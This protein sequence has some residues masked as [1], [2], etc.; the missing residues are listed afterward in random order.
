MNRVMDVG[1]ATIMADIA[2]IWDGLERA[3]TSD[4]R[5]LRDAIASTDLNTGDRNFFMLRGAK[6]SDKG[7]NEK[8]VGIVT[9]IQNGLA[10]PVW[11][12]NLRKRRP[13]IR[14]R[15][16]ID[17]QRL[18]NPSHSEFPNELS[19]RASTGAL[20]PAKTIDVGGIETSYHVAGTGQPI[21]FI[22]GGNFGTPTPR[23]ARTPGI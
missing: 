9:Q 7:D 21:V 15:N 2:V 14:S 20:P 11:P 6:F 18:C 10:I 17:R 3:K 19:F 16:G 22:Y 8:A 12:L 5:A 1:V 13:S 4:P 23:P